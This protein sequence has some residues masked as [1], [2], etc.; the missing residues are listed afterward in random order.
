LIFVVLK[1][2]S[3]EL[4]AQQFEVSSKPIGPVYLPTARHCIN[5]RTYLG[6]DETDFVTGE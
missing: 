5:M 3:T 6:D 2:Q 4:K 1:V